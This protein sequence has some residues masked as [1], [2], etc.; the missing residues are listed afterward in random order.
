MVVVVDDIVSWAVGKAMEVTVGRAL[1]AL[2]AEAGAKVSAGVACKTE[3]AK[4][5][6]SLQQPQ[7]RT[8]LEVLDTLAQR[9]YDLW[10]E[11]PRLCDLLEDAHWLV[12]V[13]ARLRRRDARRRIQYGK[14]ITAVRKELSAFGT[15]RREAYW[16][17]QHR[18]DQ[19]QAA[20]QQAAAQ[21][22]ALAAIQHAELRDAQGPL[23]IASLRTSPRPHLPASE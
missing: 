23:R 12:L 4:L 9:D 3:C 21:A 16:A 19:R 13:C 22:T 18:Y 20:E 1:D 14:R 5:A 15:G 17:A 7:L 10:P 8:L 2:I 6:Q 11:Y